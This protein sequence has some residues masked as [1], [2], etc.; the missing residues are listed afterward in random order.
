MNRYVNLSKSS[1]KP[2]S[3]LQNQV[4]RMSVKILALILKKRIYSKRWEEHCRVTFAEL[5]TT[6]EQRVI[7]NIQSGL[8]A[9][10]QVAQFSEHDW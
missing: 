8:T 7:S 10:S 9:F 6:M 5:I 1:N 2:L 4:I 3:A